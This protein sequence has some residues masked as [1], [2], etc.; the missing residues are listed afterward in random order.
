MLIITATRVF[1]LIVRSIDYI[2]NGDLGPVEIT[3]SG[4]ELWAV[5]G[6]LISLSVLL[7]LWKNMKLTAW[8]CV[9]AGAY[10]TSLGLVALMHSIPSFPDGVRVATAYASIGVVW[11]VVAVFWNGYDAV[12]KDRANR[13]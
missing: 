2:D 8:A 5:S 10:F 9:A 13:G 7:G 1:D 4:V 6:F 11:F 12:Q 3:G